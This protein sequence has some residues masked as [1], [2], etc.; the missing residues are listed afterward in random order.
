MQQPRGREAWRRNG[1]VVPLYRAGHGVSGHLHQ[2]SLTPR[3][4][5]MMRGCTMGQS[6]PP[7][8]WDNSGSSGL[9]GHTL[10]TY[11]PVWC[12]LEC[13][14]CSSSIRQETEKIIWKTHSCHWRQPNLANITVLIAVQV[15]LVTML[16]S[17]SYHSLKSLSFL[18]SN[19][20]CSSQ[21]QTLHLCGTDLYP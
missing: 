11:L 3:A 2:T 8:L 17:N 19:Y 14:W 13:P 16:V 18:S 6:A 9:Q 1:V 12:R 15:Q 20:L 5:T 21:L 4:G 7:H 10:Y